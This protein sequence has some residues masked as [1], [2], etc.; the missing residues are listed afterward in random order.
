MVRLHLVEASSH[1][2]QKLI[3][4]TLTTYADTLIVAKRD[5]QIMK[6]E[7]LAHQRSPRISFM[8]KLPYTI[9]MKNAN[10]NNSSF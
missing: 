8:S 3:T 6:R 2:K 5:E 9:R 1:Y 4:P 7:K 10:P